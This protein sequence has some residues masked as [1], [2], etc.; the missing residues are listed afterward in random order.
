[1]TET[2]NQPQEP[3]LRRLNRAR[4]D[5]NVL[6]DRCAD[7]QDHFYDAVITAMEEGFTRA[8]VARAA[9]VQPPR[10]TQIMASA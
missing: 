7:A 2:G 6:K 1:M 3:T 10:I 8:E 5:L 4:E 9:G